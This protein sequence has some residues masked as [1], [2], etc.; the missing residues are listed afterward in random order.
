MSEID[1]KTM[2][3]NNLAELCYNEARTK[4]WHRPWDLPD[5]RFHE[6]VPSF[7]ANLHGEVSELWEAYRNGALWDPCDKA[8]KMVEPLTCMEEELADI[9]IRA[10]DTA[11]AGSVDIERAVRVKLLY[12]RTRPHRHG[13]KVA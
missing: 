10:L 8:E 7:V 2:G 11:V 1:L 6:R 3:L 12:N 13:G 9:V 5:A 4:G